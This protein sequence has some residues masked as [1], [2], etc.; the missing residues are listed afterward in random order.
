MRVEE[1]LSI[2]RIERVFVNLLKVNK[3][4]KNK[5][6]DNATKNDI[7]NVIEIIQSKDYSEYT[8]QTYKTIIKKFFRWL[9]KG[10]LVDWIPYCLKSDMKQPEELLTR[11][12]VYNLIN[13]TDKVKYKALIYCLYESACRISELL[14]LKIKN[15]I[16]DNYGAILLVHGKMGYRRVRI[17]ES[18]PLLGQWLLY[19]PFKENPESPLWFE[20]GRSLSA[21]SSLKIIKHIALK[22]GIHKR[23]YH[24]LFRISRATELAN[25]LTEPQLREFMGWSL[26][27]RC[28]AFYVFLSG[29]DIDDAI[30][31][32]HKFINSPYRKSISFSF[33][34]KRESAKLL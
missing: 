13:S 25:Y 19:H 30:L 16:F 34:H 3:W 10:P 2:T 21:D 17:V 12:D 26:R 18:V 23:I 7:I 33:S 6:I 15:V 20:K 4:M 22:I 29:R 28:P 24:Q 14:S 9:D 32:M 1:G 11:E 8:I 5:D 27:S 31:R